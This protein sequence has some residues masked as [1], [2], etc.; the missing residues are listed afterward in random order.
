MIK[1]KVIIFFVLLLLFAGVLTIIE[2]NKYGSLTGFVSFNNDPGNLSGNN[3]S[4]INKN[5]FYFALL[6]IA[7]AFVLFFI[8]KYLHRYSEKNFGSSSYYGD[9]KRRRLIDLNLE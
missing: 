6:T 5:I 8:A 7:F 3:G 1:S 4:L 2:I 9:Y